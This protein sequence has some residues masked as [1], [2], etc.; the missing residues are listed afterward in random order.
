MKLRILLLSGLLLLILFFIG[1]CRS[2]GVWLVKEENVCKSDAIVI[3]MGS[4]CDRVLQTAD[5]FFTNKADSIFIVQESMD[6]YKILKDK[7]IHIIRSSEQVQNAIIAM[8]VPSKRIK[9][10]AG[11]ATSTQMEAQIIRGYI[12]HNPNVDTLLLV[13]SSEHLLR[14]SLIFNAA[15]KETNHPVIIISISNKY[16]NFNAQKWWKE[17]EGVQKVITEYVKIVNFM[18]FDKRKLRSQI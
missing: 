11:D 12:A 10:L 15:F 5:M 2:A 16:T 6:A 18:L 9:I 4:I 8:G 13:T 17:K 1:C 7:G 3:L 14:A